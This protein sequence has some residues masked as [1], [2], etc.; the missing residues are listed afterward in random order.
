MN[1]CL[2]H[3]LVSSTAICILFKFLLFSNLIGYFIFDI[4][5]T[6]ILYNIAVLINHST[7]ESRNKKK[8]RHRKIF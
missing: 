2:G 7:G 6:Y 1:K 5:D 4:A 8:A 3:S